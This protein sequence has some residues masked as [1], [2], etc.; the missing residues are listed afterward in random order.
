MSLNQMSLWNTCPGSL[1]YK[2]KACWFRSPKLVGTYSQVSIY[3]IVGIINLWKT[4]AQFHGKIFFHALG[5]CTCTVHGVNWACTAPRSGCASSIHSWLERSER[6]QLGQWAVHAQIAPW[7]SGLWAQA[8][9]QF[10][11]LGVNWPC[12][13]WV[14]LCMLRS[15]Q[16]AHGQGS[17]LRSFHG[18]ASK[19]LGTIS[20]PWTRG[21]W[22][23]LYR[24][25]L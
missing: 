25:V 20:G 23:L 4:M 2:C 22:P 15:L 9:P 13:A 3:C 16:G 1:L 7:R 11:L 14:G 18:L 12:A 10:N 17:S 6:A 24:I 5:D 8:A 19:A 21:W